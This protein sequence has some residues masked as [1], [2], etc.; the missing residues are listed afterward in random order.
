MSLARVNR[1]RGDYAQA[2]ESVRLALRVRPNDPDA[3]E[4]AADVLAARGEFENALEIYRTLRE[5]DPSR[6][7]V[8]E[9]FARL[10]IQIA[11]GKRQQML[12]KEMAENPQK[13]RS[14]AA[15]RNPAIAAVISAAPGFGQI[16]CGQLIRGVVLFVSVMVSWFF[17][18]LLRPNV[19]FY[20]PEQ[21]LEMFF[22][23][24]SPMALVFA[25]VAF[26]LH[27]Y[28]FVD[29]P[30]LASKLRDQEQGKEHKD[31]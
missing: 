8:E 2:A 30:V 1:M 18:Y 15:P 24:I 12:L 6:A 23:D 26:C 31:S 19:G 16:Y 21:R 14:K 27:V 13:Y 5:A 7:S 25:L 9:K 17:F 4:F 22:R 29:A 20:P 10:T 28:A 11:E 3:L